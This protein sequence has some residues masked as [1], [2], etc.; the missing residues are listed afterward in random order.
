MLA[1]GLGERLKE[2][3]R[4]KCR[5][6]GIATIYWTF[7]PLVARNAHLNLDRMGS[8]VDEYVVAMYGEGTNSPLQ[9][10]MPTDRFVITWAVD[11]TEVAKPL[12][13]LPTTLPLV[14][15]RGAREGPLVD[16]P[17]VGV[18]VPR[19]ITALA[20][21]DLPAARRWRAATR[22]AFSHYLPRGYHV[23]GFV[24]DAEGGTYLLVA[25]DDGHRPV[26]PAR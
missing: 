4:D 24:A 10:D 11:P 12:D 17:A 16:A 9:G 5:A 25:R 15:D 2:Y 1:L 22:R 6:M 21:T 8:R 19:D 20:A 18:R 23:R 3:Q 26:T 7:D 13:A 14:V